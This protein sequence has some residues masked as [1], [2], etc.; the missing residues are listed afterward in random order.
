M[1]PLPASYRDHDGFVFSKEGKIFR[2]VHPRYEAHYQHLQRS[3]LLQELWDNHLLIPHTEQEAISEFGFREGRIWQPEKIPFISYPYEWSF[4][5][6]K[7]AALLTLN[8]AQR[9]LK[10]GMVL[11][12]ASPF[13]VQFRNGQAVFIDTL[14]FEN[15]A[16]GNPWIAYRQ[17][18][19]CFLA[20][21]LLMRYGHPD[22]GRIFTI[23]PNGIPLGIL[24]NILPPRARWNLNNYLHIY[25]QASLSSSSIKTAGKQARLSRGKLVV[26]LDGLVG[27]VKGLSVKQEKTTWDDYYRSTILGETYLQA[28][29]QLVRS[30]TEGLSFD[31][32]IDLGAN[33]GH[34]SLLFPGKRVVALD[35]DP[36]CIE[37][38]YQQI[39]QSKSDILPLVI[40]LAAPSPA[41]GWNNR[42]RDSI[43]DRLRAD[44]VM[45]LALIHHLAIGLNL[46]LSMI[47][48]WL[49]PMGPYLLIEFVPK[50]DEKV[51][52]LLRNREDIFDGYDLA[53]FRKVFAERYSLLR[54]EPIGNTGRI[55]FLFKRN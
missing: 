10:K 40:D 33:N 26:L 28:K 21:L 20:P 9:A 34:F 6:W 3:G 15:Y 46:P 18:C 45:A 1:Q 7:D 41:I 47:A 14:S 11:K 36:N 38:L 39:K 19:E 51:Q 13:N 4:G 37:A 50:E 25:L 5:M 16:E 32:V 2:Y 24:K 27:Y 42:E 49:L 29:T 52:G 53:D 17:F 54:E 43:S 48:E 8:I 55:L 30:F 22:A 35:A 12:D 31:S 23:Y 44:L